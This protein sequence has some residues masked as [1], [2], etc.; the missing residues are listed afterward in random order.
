MPV[1]F[2][3]A[4]SRRIKV[5]IFMSASHVVPLS[6]EL[7]IYNVEYVR[8]ALANVNGPAVIDLSGVSFI[9]AAAL[10]ELIRAARRAGYRNLTL[11]G[12]NPDIRRVLRIVKVDHIFQ[13]R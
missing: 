3:D 1:Y 11:I 13:I 12:A 10:S 6:G 5:K 9:S 8:S 7:D 2:D 4:H